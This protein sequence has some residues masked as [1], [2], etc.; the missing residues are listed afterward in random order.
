MKG[1]ILG[2][3]SGLSP[4]VGGAGTQPLVPQMKGR[5]RMGFPGLFPMLQRA[6]L[7]VA[8]FR[9]PGIALPWQLR[10]SGE[11]RGKSRE[12]ERE[13]H[14]VH[15]PFGPLTVLCSLPLL[16]IHE[17]GVLRVSSQPL[18]LSAQIICCLSLLLA[19]FPV[20]PFLFALFSY[21]SMA[22]SIVYSPAEARKAL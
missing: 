13:K 15:T 18:K 7:E 17:R 9:E 11:C 22:D 19:S 16:P 10:C 20:L 5:E 1:P 14:Q 6:V 21:P 3:C 12:R 2:G 4:P 8:A